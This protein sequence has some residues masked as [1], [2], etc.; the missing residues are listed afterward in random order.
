MQAQRPARRPSQLPARSRFPTS[1]HSGR[2]SALLSRLLCIS[3][4]RRSSRK[5]GNRSLFLRR[6]P[7]RVSFAY[8]WGC[9]W[10]FVDGSVAYYVAFGPHGPR[11]PV[12]PQ[13]TTV[14][15]VAGVAVLIATAGLIY[16][17]VRAVGA[18]LFALLLLLD[19]DSFGVIESNAQPLRHQG[20]SRRSGKR[21]RTSAPR[22]TR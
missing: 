13:G 4:S 3:S 8:V 19:H 20:R 10:A 1:R 11:A 2:R 16:G 6:K 12:N 7:V 22:S 9:S 17:G 5:T 21:P 14:K 15:V 18:F